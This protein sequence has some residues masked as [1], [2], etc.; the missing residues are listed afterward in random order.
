MRIT[1]AQEKMLQRICREMDIDALEAVVPH[2]T[3][4]QIRNTIH[5]IWFL[6][7]DREDIKSLDRLWGLA[8]KDPVYKAADQVKTVCSAIKL[9]RAE[10]TQWWLD[11]LSEDYIS[12][13]VV[14]VM[15]PDQ[16]DGGSR[17]MTQSLLGVARKYPNLLS[18]AQLRSFNSKFLSFPTRDC[19]V[20]ALSKLLDFIKPAQ[21]IGP[22]RE[23][24]AFSPAQDWW[25]RVASNDSFEKLAFW[26][27]QICSNPSLFPDAPNLLELAIVN[28]NPD[29]EEIVSQP[30]HTPFSQAVEN[31]FS[32]GERS[33][34]VL[35]GLVFS[36]PAKLARMMRKNPR[37]SEL[38]LASRSSDGSNILHLMA[39]YRCRPGSEYSS[40]CLRW[41]HLERWVSKNAVH[42]LQVPNKSGE[43]PL[44]AIARHHPTWY[45][46]LSR[47][48]LMDVSSKSST[49]P[50]TQESQAPRL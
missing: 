33:R 13:A 36:T 5:R 16:D 49:A 50:S 23:V 35:A 20:L 17:N 11:R 46:S 7:S 2:Y 30:G 48:L 22:Q 15:A 41:S 37:L 44:E 25:E 40:S 19:D 29:L 32:D 31:V 6:A 3:P 26:H 14:S 43:T 8:T 27:K 21:L 38:V 10:S 42:L 9:N 39:R 18:G 1:P 4:L 12:H 45:S 47:R 28:S 34:L 24:L